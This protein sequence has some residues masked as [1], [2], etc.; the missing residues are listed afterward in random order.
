[1]QG[2][3]GVSPMK[4]QMVIG[5]LCS[6]GIVLGTSNR[7]QHDLASTLACMLSQTILGNPLGGPLSL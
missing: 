2:Y 6:Y 5:L 3:I 7:P 4:N 1:M